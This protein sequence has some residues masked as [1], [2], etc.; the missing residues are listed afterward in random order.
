MKQRIEDTVRVMP[1]KGDQGQAQH[2]KPD[3]ADH[4]GADEQH[5]ASQ[6]QRVHVQQPDREQH[7][8]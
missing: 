8:D 2:G 6:V 1:S 4:S 5:E 3:K 7:V